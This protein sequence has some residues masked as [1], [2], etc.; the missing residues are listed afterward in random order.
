VLSPP[1]TNTLPPC[2]SCGKPASHTVTDEQHQSIFL[3][4]YHYQKLFLDRDEYCSH[5]QYPEV[6]IDCGK[7]HGYDIE[8]TYVDL[9][10]EE[11]KQKEQELL[12]MVK[13]MC[14]KGCSV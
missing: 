12:R 13:R 1:E 9:P 11:Q 8:V 6:T 4:C 3:C 7:S 5:H 2:R 10:D 14:S